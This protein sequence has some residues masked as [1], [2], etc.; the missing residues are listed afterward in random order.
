MRCLCRYSCVLAT[1]EAAQRA[2]AQRVQ[3]LVARA[4]LRAFP[5]HSRSAVDGERRTA[6]AVDGTLR[7]SKLNVRMRS[8]VVLLFF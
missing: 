7:G 5:P 1:W 3:N 8:T 2:R 4:R 6:V